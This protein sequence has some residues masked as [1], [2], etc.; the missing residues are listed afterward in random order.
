[1]L[2]RILT[3][4][5]RNLLKIIRDEH[6]QAVADLARMSKRSGPNLLRTLVKF[7][8]RGLIEMQ[9][10]GRRKI[11]VARVSRLRV[12]IDPFSPNDRFEMA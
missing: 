7:E 4:E 6:P 5:N 3:P 1:M 11:P 8:A 10:A 12:E 2:L 9:T